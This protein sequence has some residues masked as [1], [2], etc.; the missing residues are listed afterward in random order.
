MSRD[1]F[2]KT[3]FAINIPGP[4]GLKTFIKLD[5]LNIQFVISYDWFTNPLTIIFS[6][7]FANMDFGSALT[8]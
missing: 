7:Y 5:F 3:E 8:G 4:R 1:L 2:A 6:S